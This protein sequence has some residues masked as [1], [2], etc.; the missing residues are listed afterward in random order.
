MAGKSDSDSPFVTTNTFM[1]RIRASQETKPPGRPF[2]VVAPLTVPCVAV[3]IAAP[4]PVDVARPVLMMVA[5]RG[6]LELQD[7]A[8]VMFAVDPS[9]KLPVAVYCVLL[10]TPT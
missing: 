1:S 2:I 4:P 6:L 7:T 3:M 9:L 5:N 8:L 10:P